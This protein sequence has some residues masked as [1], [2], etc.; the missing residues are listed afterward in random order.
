M[1]IFLRYTC[2]RDLVSSVSSGRVNEIPTPL[3]AVF[4]GDRLHETI[5][6]WTLILVNGCRVTT[7]RSSEGEKK[8][9]RLAF[10]AN[11]TPDIEHGSL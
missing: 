7:L 2:Q 10:R 9:T 4:C 5:R 6:W 11:Q 3:Q 8:W 1:L